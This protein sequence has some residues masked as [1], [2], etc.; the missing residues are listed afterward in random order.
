MAVKGSKTS[1]RS[2]Y[3]VLGFVKNE[4]TIP[5]ENGKDAY[6]EALAVQTLVKEVDGRDVWFAITD[7]AVICH[8]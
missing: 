6:G 5:K 1:P 8:I 7:T 4:L 2:A 3:K